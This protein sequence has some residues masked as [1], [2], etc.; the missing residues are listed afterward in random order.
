MN[1][2]RLYAGIC[3]LLEGS[4]EIIERSFDNVCAEPPNS[5]LF[6]FGRR[7]DDNHGAARTAFVRGQRDALCGVARAGRPYALRALRIA[8][9]SY[10]VVRAA[11]FKRADRLQVFEFEINRI[12]GMRRVER[13]E[14]RSKRCLVNVLRGIANSVQRNLSRRLNVHRCTPLATGIV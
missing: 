8:E 5:F 1:E 14:R 4:P 2:M 12:G 13:N 9:L 3:S 6:G 10:R 7:V 11:Y